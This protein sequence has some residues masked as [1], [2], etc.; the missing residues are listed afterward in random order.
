MSSE[1]FQSSLQTVIGR[2]VISADD[3]FI[4]KLEFN[5]DLVVS[6]NPDIP[7]HLAESVLQISAYFEHPTDTE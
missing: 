1:V 7:E 2:I 6:T 5:D 4:T 3:Q